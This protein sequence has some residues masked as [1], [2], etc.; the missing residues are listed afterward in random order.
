LVVA[1]GGAYFSRCGPRLLDGLE[2]L[3]EI[4]H[5]ELF[6]GLVAAQAASR[7]YGRL[8]KVS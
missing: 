7:I 3:A 5:P 1:D 8:F 6:S 2:T 4:L